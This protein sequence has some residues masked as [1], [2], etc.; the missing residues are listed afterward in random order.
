LPSAISPLSELDPSAEQL[1]LGDFL[2]GLDERLL[3]DQRALVGAH[4]LLQLV[5]VAPTVLGVDDDRVASTKSIT[6]ALRAS[7]TSPV[8]CAARRSMPVPISGRVRLQERHR[9]ALHVR[10]HQGAVG[11][12][13]LEERDHRRGDGPDLLGETSI[14]STSAGLDVDV[15]T[16]WRAA[17][18]AVARERAVLVDRLVGLRDQAAP[19]PRS[20]PGAGSRR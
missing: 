18:D 16:R 12:V 5:L 20:R 13:V 7:S 11:V 8:S 6:P 15:L 2:P 10:A 9:L 17:E 3:V 1:P 4:E 14:R 19:A